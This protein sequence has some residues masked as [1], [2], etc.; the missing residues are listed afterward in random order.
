MKMVV[1]NWKMF[2]TLSD[3][4]VLTGMVKTAAEQLKGV[5]IVIAPPSPWIVPV[6]ESIRHRLNNFHLAAQNVWPED[7][8]AH[9]GEV[10]A[11]LLRNLVEYAIL[12]HSERRR[13]QR[14]DNDLIHDK[15]ISCLK[16]GI[17][18]ILCVGETKPVF[19]H[20]GATDDYQ[21]NRILE[22][23]TD[24][25][26]GVADDGLSRII[27]AHEPVFAVGTKRPV[28]PQYAS[29]VIHRLRLKLQEKFG[30]VG[31][32]LPILY[33]G[34]VEANNVASYL[35]SPGID[36]LLIGSMSVRGRDFIKACQIAAGLR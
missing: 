18:P 3:A 5:E 19:A 24:A 15:L 20:D 4:L 21:L 35:R 10:S 31:Y 22:Q 27:I 8:G 29:E 34:S 1:G 9:T 7:Q 25:L 23:L 33:G 28:K 16:W 2:P 26:E 17:K 6:A 36:G 12:G 32:R 14:E 11:Y 13:D 30:E